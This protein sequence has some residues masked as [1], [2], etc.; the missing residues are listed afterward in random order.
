MRLRS[1]ASTLLCR[2]PRR[3][4]TGRYSESFAFDLL[5]SIGRRRRALWLLFHSCTRWVARLVAAF[6]QCPPV[7]SASTARRAYPVSV[8]TAPPQCLPADPTITSS[9]IMHTSFVGV[10]RRYQHAAA[11]AVDVI[12]IVIVISGNSTSWSSPVTITANLTVSV[13][14]RG[15]NTSAVSVIPS[16]QML[17]SR[18]QHC[19]IGDWWLAVPTAVWEMQ[20]A[21]LVVWRQHQSTN[22]QRAVRC[23][24]SESTSLH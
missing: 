10:A 14:L 5:R 4:E 11:A 12:V 9:S 21:L 19:L 13:G 22:T 3:K 18:I 16:S 2:L 1:S 17:L 20:S 23:A 8:C 6:L 15:Y 24:G 7:L